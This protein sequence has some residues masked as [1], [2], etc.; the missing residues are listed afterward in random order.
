MRIP[1]ALLALCFAPLSLA[2]HLRISVASNTILPHPSTLPPS[3]HAE[4]IT[5]G[6]VFTAPLRADNTFDFR[7][8]TSGSYLLEVYSH[9]Y[10]FMP[11][12]V[13][14]HEGIK[15]QEGGA[16]VVSTSE[17]DVFGTFRGNEWGNKGE[18]IPVKEVDGKVGV[19]GFEVKAL[20]SK[21]YFIVKT[22]CEFGCPISSS[23]S[24]AMWYC[25]NFKC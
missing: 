20:G 24:T 11:L 14:V 22:G 5:L 6:H 7:N 8:V 25:W 13:D 12:R 2:V 23:F 9:T 21:E 4:L 18:V 15:L 3:T 1:S 10:A 19:W 17:V 16:G